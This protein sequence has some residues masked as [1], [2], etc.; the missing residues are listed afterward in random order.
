MKNIGLLISEMNG[1]G[2]ERVVSHLSHILNGKYN[3]FVILYEDTYMEYRCAGT[4][5]NMNL[6]TRE[7]L[8]GKI[9]LLLARTRK[10]KEIEKQY[11]LECVISFMESPNMVNLLDTSKKCK[12]II[13]IRNYTKSENNGSALG[14]LVNI[15]M[16]NLYN[17]AD[18]IIAVSKVIAESLENDY[19]LDRD[20]I[21]VI[22]NPYNIADIRNKMKDENFEVDIEKYIKDKIVFISV[23]RFNYQKGFWHLI[24]SFSILHKQCPNSSLILVGEDY[25]EGAAEK[26]VRELHLEEV[27]CFTG[28]VKNPYKYMNVSDVYVLSSLFEGFPN[29]MTE[30]MICGCAVIATDCKSGP[31]EIL[32]ETSNLDDEVSDIQRADFGIIVPPLEAQEDW[33]SQSITQG[34][35][36]LFA[37]MKL[38]YEDHQLRE[39]LKEDAK[40][41]GHTFTFETC[42]KKYVDVIEN[43]RV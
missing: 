37:A 10:L 31:R 26:L 35:K 9:G 6:P 7:G 30:A 43:D 15:A 12:K 41:R 4:I 3:V 27:I 22:Y 19:K 2:A 39:I 34:E 11:K 23:G 28:R 13:S 14:L 25:T 24:K 8:L 16:T 33:R 32:F 1:G 29:A 42:L 36:N 18:K 17:R 40:K 38:V 21:A 20:K 5:I